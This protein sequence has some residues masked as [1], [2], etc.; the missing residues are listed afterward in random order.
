MILACVVLTQYRSV[1]DGQTDRQTDAQTIAKTREA[2]HAGARKKQRT[3][4]NANVYTWLRGQKE[5]QLSIVKA[6]PTAYV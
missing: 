2:L 6:D 3:S 4:V 1:P 5:A